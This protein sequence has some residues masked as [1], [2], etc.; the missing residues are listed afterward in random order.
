MSFTLLD[1]AL[2]LIVLATFIMCNGS[3]KGDRY[4]NS[5]ML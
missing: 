4:E 5:G 2:R 1:F 3:M